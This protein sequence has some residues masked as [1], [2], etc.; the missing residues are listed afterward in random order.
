MHL[1]HGTLEAFGKL[2]V[3][4]AELGVAPGLDWVIGTVFVADLG[5]VFFP[6]QHEGHA[7]AGQFL[8]NAPK[9]GLG[10]AV[11]GAGRCQQASLQR[12]FVHGCN[13]CPVQS[14]GHRQ[15]HVLGDNAFGNTQ[16][17]GDLLVGLSA[18]EFETQG[19]LEFAHIDP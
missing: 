14:G 11:A 17:I 16:S 12:G 19:V 2:A 5:A 8:V 18:L 10:V 15:A 9:V 1:A 3:V 4:L 13:R 7:L 6:Q